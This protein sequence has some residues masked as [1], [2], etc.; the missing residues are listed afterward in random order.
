MNAAEPM[1]C[2]L[3][4]GRDYA[5]RVARELDLDLSL[6]EERVFED[7]EYKIRPLTSVR[8]RDVYVVQSLH[9]EPG[10][11]VNDKLCRLLFFLG[12]LRDAGAGR[13]TAVVPYLAFAR[14]D[15]RTKA[16]D[17][18]TTRYL[19]CL[20]ESLGVDCV[21]TLDVHN[22]AAFQNAFR[23]RSIHMEAAGLFAAHLATRMRAAD[24]VVMSPDIGGVKRAERFREVLQA[25]LGRPVG[26]AFMEKT[27]S[28]GIVAGGAVV[29]EVADKE[30]VVI[31][32]L[33]AAGTTMARAARAAAALGARAVHALATHGLFVGDANTLL[34]DPLLE[35]VIVTDSVPPFR[36]HAEDVRRKLVVLETA[37]LVAEVIRRLRGAGPVSELFVA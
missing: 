20:F 10:L 24:P 5:G 11:S 2:A 6:P 33:I 12:A 35:S 8:D 26:M 19:A 13:L 4:C 17:P 14:K 22:L 32:D 34:A 16:R 29:G 27:R 23:C 28:A 18:V 9:G 25:L 15:R 21:V 1:I 30:V 3:G 7:G 36:I 31:D 37:P